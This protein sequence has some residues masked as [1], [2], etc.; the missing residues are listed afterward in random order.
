MKSS[1]EKHFATDLAKIGKTMNFEYANQQNNMKINIVYAQHFTL[2]V[3]TLANFQ[4]LCIYLRTLWVSSLCIRS[5]TECPYRPQ[6]WTNAPS[7]L[8]APATSHSK[9]SQKR[10]K[11]KEKH[12]PLKGIYMCI[13]FL[14]FTRGQYQ[15][16]LM[17]TNIILF[18]SN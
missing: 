18:L 16:S 9:L 13:I 10:N 5:N 2:V 8:I 11:G 12:Y 15:I 4:G 3:L 6:Q 17:L 7:L 1:N 14:L